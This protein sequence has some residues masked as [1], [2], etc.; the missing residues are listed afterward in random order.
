[1]P[2]YKQ[3]EWEGKFFHLGRC[4][5]FCGDPLTIRSATKEHLLPRERGGNDELINIVP[6]CWR[7]N[8]LKGT[9]TAEEF[10]AAFPQICKS[11]T[12]N[13]YP[14]SGRVLISY[15][16][17][18]EPGLLKRVKAESERVSWAWRNP[19]PAGVPYT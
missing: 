5:Y 19:P 17:K 2:C 11:S 18:N 9:R 10:R 7:C 1:M 4:C 12:A 6:A 15:E 14:N 8:H 3:I 13:P 16:E